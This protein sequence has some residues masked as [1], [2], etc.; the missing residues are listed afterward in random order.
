MADVMTDPS[1][2][3]ISAGED[4]IDAAVVAEALGLEPSV[5]QRQMRDGEI[6]S[7]YERGMDEDAG[8]HRLTFIAGKQRLTFVVDDQ[9]NVIDR[10]TL[11]LGGQ[12]ES[13]TGPSG[14]MHETPTSK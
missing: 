14:R 1:K 2:I 4:E 10:S 7:R 9:G 13:E 5:L 8:R 12:P 11:T 6:T 3:Q